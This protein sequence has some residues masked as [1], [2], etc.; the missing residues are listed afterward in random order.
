MCVRNVALLVASSSIDSA[1]NVEWDRFREL[2]ESLGE[3]LWVSRGR[4]LCTGDDCRDLRWISLIHFLSLYNE[5]W[6]FAYSLLGPHFNAIN[7]LSKERKNPSALRLCIN[8][9]NFKWNELKCRK[10]CNSNLIN[11]Y[12]W[13]RNYHRHD[14]I[15]RAHTQAIPLRTSRTKN[16]SHFQYAANAVNEFIMNINGVQFCLSLF[17]PLFG[18]RWLLLR[19]WNHLLL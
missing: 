2:H 8:V 15:S 9:L 7:K 13:W 4:F 14:W 1:I 5:L 10:K 18:S 12:L 16:L 17:L 3:Y 19:V 6:L 11:A